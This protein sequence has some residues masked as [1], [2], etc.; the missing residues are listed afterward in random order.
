MKLLGLCL[1]ALSSILAVVLAIW[2]PSLALAMLFIWL[3]WALV[4]L[5]R[6]GS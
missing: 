4:A 3:V 2:Y 5:Y 1:M 6:S